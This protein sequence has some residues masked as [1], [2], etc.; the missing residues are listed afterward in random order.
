MGRNYYVAR[1]WYCLSLAK[2]YRQ[3]DDPAY[4]AL[5]LDRAGKNRREAL[6]YVN[7]ERW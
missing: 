3:V 5:M 2:F 6:A 7:G 4:A 1:A